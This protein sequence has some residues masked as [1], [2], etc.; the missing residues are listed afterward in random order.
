MDNV[1][2]YDGSIFWSKTGHISLVDDWNRAK[3]VT[4]TTIGLMLDVK[5]HD[6]ATVTAYKDGVMMGRVLSTISMVPL[7]T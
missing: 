2:L 7:L 5:Q 3:I 1:P 6:T 4:G